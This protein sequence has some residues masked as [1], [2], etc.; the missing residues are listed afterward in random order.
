MAFLSIETDYSLVQCM[1]LHPAKQCK[2]ITLLT[3][4]VVNA[5][6]CIFTQKHFLVYLRYPMISRIYVE[7]C[8]I[9]SPSFTLFIWGIKGSIGKYL[10]NYPRLL[11]AKTLTNSSLGRLI[12]YTASSTCLVYI[13]CRHSWMLLVCIYIS[14]ALI[15]WISISKS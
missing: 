3:K 4:C 10:I 9:W 14:I 5:I 6:H 1:I 15:H 2:C 7:I 11:L 13:V 8:L 12:Y